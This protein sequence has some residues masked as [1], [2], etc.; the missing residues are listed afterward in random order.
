LKYTDPSGEFIWFVA[1]GF[2][3]GA[4][5]GGA[6]SA[7]DGGFKGAEWNPFNGSWKDTD[8]WK[9]AIVGGIVGAGAGALAASAFG[10]ASTML[11]MQN[12]T[13]TGSSMSWSM[14]SSG[15]LMGNLNMGMTALSG[16]DMDALW[17]SGVS[18]LISGAISG[19]I[20]NYMNPRFSSIG[21][22]KGAGIH[23]TIGG[24][25]SL[26]DGAITG[27]KGNE[28][29][30][31]TL[32]GAVTSALM[33]GISEGIQSRFDGKSF[34]TG[35]NKRIKYADGCYRNILRDPLSL[36]AD[37]EFTAAIFP[38]FKVGD[39]TVSIPI[40]I[41]WDFRGKPNWNTIYE[42]ILNGERNYYDVWYNFPIL[43]PFVPFVK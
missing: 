33:G 38:S 39:K 21:F 13:A 22:W 25:T 6:I 23:G 8:W 26:I 41:G 7:G 2:V 40:G 5:I 10:G 35:N 19:G 34:W 37:S 9:G 14:T 31:H 30:N 20:S 36:K 3:V 11:L 32:K 24:V 12:A 1:I 27:L 43:V 17:K 4:Y 15:L 18:G 16:G 29:L 42:H 28:L